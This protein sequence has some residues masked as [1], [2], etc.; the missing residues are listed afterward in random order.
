MK[1][2]LIAGNSTMPSSVGIFNIPA[3]KTCTPSDWCKE[4]C[5][6]LQGRFVWK[7]IKKA[8][9]W[10]YKES[11]KDSFPY[12]MIKEIKRRRSLKWIRIHITGDFYSKEYVDK[13]NIVARSFPEIIFRTNTKRQD[14]IPYMFATFPPNVVLRESIDTT[15]KPLLPNLI[16]VAAIKGTPGSE[17]YFVCKDDCEKCRFSCWSNKHIHVV[18]GVIR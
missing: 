16:P 5:Y 4:H 10:R 2:M 17:N 14:L 12:K 8:H 3:L 13:W 9:E 7:P 18:S 1:K 15:R 11:L 6:A